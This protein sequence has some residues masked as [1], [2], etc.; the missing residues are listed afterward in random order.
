MFVKLTPPVLNPQTVL[1]SVAGTRPM[2]EGS[3]NISIEERGNKKI[4]HCY[5]HGGSGWTTLF[6]SIEEA[7]GLLSK[8]N[9]P[10]RILGAG[11]MGLT[12]AIELVRNGFQVAGITAKNEFDIA[13][14]VAACYF[15]MVSVQTSK[16]EEKRHN[17]IALSTFI[18]YQQIEK[19]DHPY[20]GKEFVRFLPV[21]CSHETEAGVEELAKVGLISKAEEVTLDFGNVTHKN[22]LKYMTYFMDSA[23]LMQR[24]RQVVKSLKLAIDL[25]EIESFEQVQEEIVINC[26][27]LG[28]KKL[29]NDAKLVGV[30][31]HLIML[32][33]LAG[34]RH[35]NYMI[36]SKLDDGKYVYLFPKSQDASGLQC[37]GV[38]G[39]S[40][41]P[42]C[43]QMTDKELVNLDYQEFNAILARNRQFFHGT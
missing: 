27:G 3:F 19:G 42:S 39:A 17:K 32:N 15:G 25:Q 22:Y 23:P 2:R 10:I 11:C 12:M 18:T 33:S 26:T 6:G 37:F 38:L 35:M 41:I 4:I 21:Y 30:R 1:K 43:D 36:Y 16:E 31:G 20:I 29:N 24:L 34:N 13:S 9:Q 14:W 28:S 5:G 40:F 8:T 7:L